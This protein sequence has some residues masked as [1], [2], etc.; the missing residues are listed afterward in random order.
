M[1]CDSWLLD[2]LSFGGKVYSVLRRRV[3]ACREGPL[4]GTSGGAGSG[5]DSS[6]TSR[7]KHGLLKIRKHKKN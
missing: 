5:G 4:G 6:L 7:T 2:L 1:N 3:A